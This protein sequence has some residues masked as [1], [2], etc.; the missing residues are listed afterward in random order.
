MISTISS[1]FKESKIV[2]NLLNSLL[3]ISGFLPLISNEWLFENIFTLILVGSLT[4]MFTSSNPSFFNNSKN[5]FLTGSPKKL[6]ALFSN[7][8]L[9]KITEALI[10]FP[11]G[12]N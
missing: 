3:V 4:S 5:R 7:P 10:P 12:N 9:F 6:I 2:F 1:W 11:P 8:I